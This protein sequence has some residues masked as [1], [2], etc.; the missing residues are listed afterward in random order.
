MCRINYHENMYLEVAT[1]IITM[2]LDVI[3]QLRSYAYV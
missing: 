1:I 3:R 2:D